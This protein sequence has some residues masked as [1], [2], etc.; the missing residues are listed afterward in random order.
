MPMK[1]KRV[2]GGI[3]LLT[4]KNVTKNIG[5]RWK[6]K[7]MGR[8]MMMIPVMKNTIPWKC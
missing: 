3:N 2:A 7:V 1:V 8:I 6:T 5:D 4:L